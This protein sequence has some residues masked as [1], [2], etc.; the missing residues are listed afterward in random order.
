MSKATNDA[1]QSLRTLLDANELTREVV[2]RVERNRIYLGRKELPGPFSEDEIDESI[3]LDPVSG[4]GFGL[5][6]KRHTGRWERTPHAGSLDHVVEVI[7]T[8][9]QHLVAPW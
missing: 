7:C 1:A 3:R 5:S 6:V 2:L 9:M 8:Q 4:V